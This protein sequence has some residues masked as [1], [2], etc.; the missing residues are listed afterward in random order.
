M[1]FIDKITFYKRDENGRGRKRFKKK[2][3]PF[4]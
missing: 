2:K 3:N 1:A 4:F